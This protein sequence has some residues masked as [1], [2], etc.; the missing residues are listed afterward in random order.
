MTYN[1]VWYV[2]YLLT[3]HTT[4]CF[5]YRFWPSSGCIWKNLSISYTRVWV[6]RWQGWVRVRDLIFALRMHGLSVMLL[7]A[8]HIY[9]TINSRVGYMKYCYTVSVLMCWVRTSAY[10]RTILTISL[11]GRNFFVHDVLLYSA[12]FINNSA[13]REYVSVLQYLNVCIRSIYIHEI[14]FYEQWWCV[15]L[16]Y[17]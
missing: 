3:W 11:Y 4:T 17:N 1:Y 6:I 2:K 8:W 13:L 15:A 14:K 9:K 7:A 12:R 16:W 10:Y 5:G